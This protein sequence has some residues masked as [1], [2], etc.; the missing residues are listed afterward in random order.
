MT[1]FNRITEFFSHLLKRDDEVP[2][3]EESI[4]SLIKAYVWSGQYTKED[5][6]VLVAEWV[7]QN[8][9]DSEP[10]LLTAVEQQFKAK[11]KAEK[12]WPER[13]DYDRLCV[14]F[15]RLRA[16]G[17]YCLHRAGATP[18]EGHK[19]ALHVMGQEVS[20]CSTYCF[21]SVQDMFQ[22]IASKGLVLHIGAIACT[23]TVQT[24]VLERI[25]DVLRQS[26]L[27]VKTEQTAD[28]VILLPMFDWKLR[29]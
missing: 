14:A 21:Y 16:E 13:L 26:G 7:A 2:S 23:T 10:V 4:L 25:A 5:V 3:A 17:I 18:S 27:A 9:V 12:T 29:S 24:L 15:D 19:E 8:A 22:A 1:V 28:N 11:R 20:D 6:K